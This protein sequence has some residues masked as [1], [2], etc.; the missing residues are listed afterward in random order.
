MLQFIGYCL[1]RTA[2]YEK[3]ALCIGKGDNG[4]GTLLKLIGRFLGVRNTSHATLQEL[5]GGDRF[6]AADGKLAN[7]FADLKNDKPPGT[8][9][10]K[11]LVS[12][13]MQRAQRKYGQ[14]FHM[15]NYAKLIFSCNNIP[16]SDDSG[17][18]YFKRWILFHF[19]HIF[20]GSDKDTKLIDKLSTPEELSGPLNLCLIMLRQLVKDDGFSR[21]D[22]IAVVE[23]DYKLNSNTV[24]K[25][26][27]FMCD[28][29]TSNHW[30]YVRSAKLYEEYA[31][32][33]KKYDLTLLADNVFGME[34]AGKH[35]EKKRL[36]LGGGEELVYVYKGV[37]LKEF[38]PSVP[39]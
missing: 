13:D 1:Y 7:T 23:K 33:C 18:A 21:L 25:F 19:E 30:W 34:L 10:F 16:E 2:K 3:A 4:K 12:G 14:P 22:D 15:A 36:R 39:S 26:L 24:E 17:Y 27:E 32:F 9:P 6:A 37:Q 38:V 20:T 28:V 11:I 31:A 29:E 5:S 35:I 8:G